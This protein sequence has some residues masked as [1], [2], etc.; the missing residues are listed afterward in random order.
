MHKFHAELEEANQRLR[1][2]LALNKMLDSHCQA[3]ESAKRDLELQLESTMDSSS[4]AEREADKVAIY[5][6]FL[7]MAYVAT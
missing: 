3:L 1:E 6:G 7:L 2:L 4:D 5:Y